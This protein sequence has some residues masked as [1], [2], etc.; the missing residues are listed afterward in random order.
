MDKLIFFLV[1]ICMFAKKTQKHAKYI[2]LYIIFLYYFR[3]KT[4]KHTKHKK[5]IWS[6]PA[7]QRATYG[8][9]GVGQLGVGKN[10][11]HWNFQ[12]ASKNC[13]Y[14]SPGNPRTP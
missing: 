11:Q 12:D 5:H 14:T 8:S 13:G 10:P 1:Y 7:T 3:K 2:S 4:Q 6:F 9:V